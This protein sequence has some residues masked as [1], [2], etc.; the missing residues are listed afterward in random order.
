MDEAVWKVSDANST[1]STDWSH[2]QPMKECISGRALHI[3]V[4]ANGAG[5]LV[6]VGV[7]HVKLC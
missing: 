2:T 3:L 4:I 5:N 7:T 6:D 1:E